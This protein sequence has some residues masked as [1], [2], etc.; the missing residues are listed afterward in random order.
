[1]MMSAERV[2]GRRG[3]VMF[4]EDSPESSDIIE[5]ITELESDN[6]QLSYQQNRRSYV[7]Y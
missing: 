6:P 4:R 1:M 5:P 2:R 3:H 7:V